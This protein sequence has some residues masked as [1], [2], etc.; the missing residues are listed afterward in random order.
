MDIL[1]NTNREKIIGK[2]GIIP[3]LMAGDK[4]HKFDTC[5]PGGC[6]ALRVAGC[7]DPC[8]HCNCECPSNC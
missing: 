1:I 3:F 8:N 2:P 5:G 4:K 6:D 7:A